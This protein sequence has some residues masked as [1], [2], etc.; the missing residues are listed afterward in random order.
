MRTF[1]AR[2][3]PISAFGTPLRG[4]TL[5]G[6]LCWAIRNRHGE[7]RL[8]TLLD[9]YTDRKPFAVVSDA[10]PAG[11]LPRPTLP[12]HWFSE[13]K[14]IDRKVVKK[15]DWLPLDQFHTPVST[16]LE[17]CLPYSAIPG[18]AVDEY[19]QPHNTLNRNTGTTGEGQFAP[20]V[21]PQLWYGKKKRN[22]RE[23]EEAVLLD[24]YVVLDQ[25]RLHHRRIT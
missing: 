9:G 25:A 1:R 21:M 18:A 7:D 16:W 12:R 6:Q 15:R 2:I 22:V 23:D 8:N 5:F 3:T 24:L 19:P 10:F 4:D 11:H 20:Y 17:H 13:M 14:N